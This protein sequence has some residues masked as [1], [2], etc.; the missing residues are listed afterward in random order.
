MSESHRV[1]CPRCVVP[2][3]R[4][5]A[6]G[7]AC[8]EHGEVAPLWKPT[9]VTYAAFTEHLARAGTFPTY[10][11]WPLG[12]GWSVTD[13]AVVEDGVPRATMTCVSGA[14]ALDGPVDVMVVSEETGTG[15]GARVAGLPA[16][17]DGLPGRP[18]H[19]GVAD[20]PPEVKVKLDAH[21][22]GLWPVSTSRSEVEWDRSVLAGEAHGRWLWLVLRPASAILLLRD[23]WILRDVSVTGPQ[24]VT[25]P[26][27]GPAP[28]W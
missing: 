24:L 15:L 17:P 28:S 21:T 16:G 5:G 9:E 1:G 20:G 11:P 14:T 7:W 25:L 18:L 27:G 22:V 13:F 26:F 2:I 19:G 10:L 3:A 12:P 8:P 4:T 6:G 23:L